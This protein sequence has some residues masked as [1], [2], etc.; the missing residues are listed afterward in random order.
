MVLTYSLP[1]SQSVLLFIETSHHIYYP[2][3]LE[4]KLI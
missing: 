4:G 3:R 1:S 2:Q